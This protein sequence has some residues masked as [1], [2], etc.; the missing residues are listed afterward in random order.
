MLATLDQARAVQAA[1]PTA[2]V[3]VYP[4]R[5]IPGNPMYRQAIELGYRPPSNFR[6]WGHMLD[7]HTMNVWKGHIPAAV[8][9]TRRLYY[10]YASYVRDSEP[11][12]DGFMVRV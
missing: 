2:S 7:Y 6:E 5:P 9:R 12:D 11:A 4:F 1:C 10:Q 3:E 8:E